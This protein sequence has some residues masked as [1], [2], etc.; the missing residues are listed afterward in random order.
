MFK[1]DS[2]TSRK[3]LGEGSAALKQANATEEK[4][5][6]GEV[7][8]E[9]ILDTAIRLFRENGF[10]ETTMRGV[11]AEAGVALGLTYHYFPSK[12]AMVMAYYERVQQEHRAMASERMT[13]M[14]S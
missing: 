2:R 9:Q 6:R 12:E 7:A 11:A 13:K 8:R 14:T 4:V 5:S 10:D 3:A 1:M